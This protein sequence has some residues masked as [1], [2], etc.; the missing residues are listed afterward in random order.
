MS[1]RDFP[2][3][4]K[5]AFCGW[6]SKVPGELALTK[7]QRERNTGI[8]SEDDDER[9]AVERVQFKNLWPAFV[10]GAG[11]FSDGYVNNSISTVTTCLSIIYGETYTN[12]NA[13]SNVAAIAFAGIVFGQLSFGY[14]SDHFA[15]KGGML[16]ANILLIVFTILCA[17]ATWGKTPEGMF[18]ALT[19]FRFFLGIAI[20]AE[21]PTASVI[22][23]EFANQLPVGH[24]NRYFIWFTHSCVDLGYVVAAFVPMVL[25]WIFSESRLEVIWRLTLGLGAVPIIALFFMRRKIKNSESY[26]KT[27]MKS[28]KKFPWLLVIKFYWFR[29][30]ISSLIWFIYDFSAYAFASYSSYILRIIVPGGDLYKTFGWTVVFNLFYLPGT[31]IGALFADYFGPRLTMVAGLV[32]QAVIGFGMTAGFETL[33]RNIGSFVAVYGVFTALGEFGAGNNTSVLAS[34]TSATPIRGQY[35]GIAAAVGKVGAFVGTYLFPVIMR[36]HGGIDSNEGVKTTFY[37]ASALCLFSAF[38]ALF[39]C[40]SV[41]QEAIDEEDRK[42]LEYLKDN[43]YDLS[44]VG[45][46]SLVEDLTEKGERMSDNSTKSDLHVLVSEAASTSKKN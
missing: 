3:S 13:I 37:V 44:L 33:Q 24:R 16:T 38:L 5:D 21:Y 18:A 31:L 36:N 40:P 29:L 7:A 20:G 32:A 2:H 34:K 11:L 46:G 28:V 42:F 25:L 41:G 39:F 9:V 17:V 23:S 26:E 43:N 4:F 45:D 22:A 27:N 15:R 8:S 35:Y 6:Y 1:T 12:S 30:T 10:S 14:I 19:T